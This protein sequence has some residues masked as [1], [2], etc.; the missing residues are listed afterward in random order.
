[1]TVKE[2]IEK[3]FS[4]NRTK[5]HIRLM[6]ATTRRGI[7]QHWLG[8]ADFT[9]VATKVTEKYL[10]IFIQAETA[11]KRSDDRAPAIST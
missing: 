4:N 2:Y 7:N 3:Y 1:M 5:K 10:F 11:S 6:N 8:Y 9:V